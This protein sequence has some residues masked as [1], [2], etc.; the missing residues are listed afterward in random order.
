M[1]HIIYALTKYRDYYCRNSKATVSSS[2]IIFIEH[3]IDF[4]KYLKRSQWHYLENSDL[5]VDEGFLES[6]VLAICTS[7]QG[8][9]TKDIVLGT[10]NFAEKKFHYPHQT[11]NNMPL[12]EVYAWKYLDD[13]DEYYA[14]EKEFEQV[15]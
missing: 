6:S 4:M 8:T 11:V 1:K 14:K 15:L 9:K 10:Y 13:V 12:Q 7:M 5:P 2:F 3:L